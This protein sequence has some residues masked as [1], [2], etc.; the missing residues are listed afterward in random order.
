LLDTP[1]ATLVFEHDRGAMRS[2]PAVSPSR[3]SDYDSLQVAALLGEEIFAVLGVLALA[4]LQNT[5]G[6]ES[7]EALRQNIGSHAQ[8]SL[9]VG[10]AG[11]SAKEG[12]TKD[13]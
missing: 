8:A 11:R 7:F 6:D 3:E 9:K 4:G 13:K 5:G 1:S 12:V 10:E 2:G